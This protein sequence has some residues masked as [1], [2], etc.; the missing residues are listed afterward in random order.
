M[1]LEL[2]GKSS[3]HQLGPVYKSLRRLATLHTSR[4]PAAALLRSA[5]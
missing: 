1:N 4:A 2:P 3:M 5:Q